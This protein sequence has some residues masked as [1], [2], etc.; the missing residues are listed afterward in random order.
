MSKRPT[1]AAIATAKFDTAKFGP[2]LSHNLGH[3]VVPGPL[4]EKLSTFNADTSRGFNALQ[5]C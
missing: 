1:P 4:L 3:S 5:A 2:I